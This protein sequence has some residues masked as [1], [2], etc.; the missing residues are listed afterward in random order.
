MAI[1]LRSL[2]QQAGLSQDA[3]AQKLNFSRPQIS[4][5]ETGEREI[6][7]KVAEAWVEAC[8]GRLVVL[9]IRRDEIALS[10]ERLSG[11]DRDLVARLVDLMPLDP[12]YE[13]S[14]RALI[15]GWERTRRL[16]DCKENVKGRTR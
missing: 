11:T 16:D 4:R 6:D 7:L 13:V 12:G 3:L 15:E 8:G 10:L 9:D 14:L 2:R 1:E 5:L